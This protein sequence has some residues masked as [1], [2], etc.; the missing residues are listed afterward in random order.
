MNIEKRGEKN[1][2][3]EKKIRLE[4]WATNIKG[5]TAERTKGYSVVQMGG[6]DSA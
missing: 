6:G 3:H 4:P 1:T 5:K 2:N